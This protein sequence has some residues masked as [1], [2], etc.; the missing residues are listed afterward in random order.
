MELQRQNQILR[1]EREVAGFEKDLG[2]SSSHLSMSPP[3]TG[4]F[5]MS[6]EPGK[7]QFTIP[8]GWSE[9]SART[10]KGKD[11]HSDDE[12]PDKYVTY[13]KT[14]VGS[15]DMASK[16]MMKHALFD[17]TVALTDYKAHFEACAD[18][19]GWSNEQEGLIFLSL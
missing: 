13:R 19:N 15:K 3:M 18:L 6:S 16:T 17:G 10:D 2:K 8:P 9:D 11:E 7:L 12:K 1:L 5:D 14:K 4:R